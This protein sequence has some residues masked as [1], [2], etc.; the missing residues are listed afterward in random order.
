MKTLLA[1]LLALGLV[2][3][4]ASVATAQGGAGSKW[5]VSAG[6]Y[7]PMDNDTG[8][9]LGATWLTL[10]ATCDLAGTD[11]AVHRVGLGWI[12]APGKKATEWV[13]GYGVVNAEW[14]HSFVPLTYTYALTPTG[15][16]NGVYYG[17]GGG[18]YFSSTDVKL[19]ASGQNVTISEDNIWVGL[20]AVGGYALSERFAAEL[21]YTHIFDSVDADF[22]GV[23]FGL[24]AAF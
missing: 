22:N 11:V 15:R 10:G 4:T 1:V 24:N 20:H 16:G 13:S 9:I 21:R 6:A 23:S 17:A 2:T 5:G 18:I 7:F 3:A 14:D 8:D 19:T 12:Y